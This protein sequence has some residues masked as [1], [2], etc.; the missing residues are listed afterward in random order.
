M[1]PTPPSSSDGS[2]PPRHRPNKTDHAKDTTEQDLWAFEEGEPLEEVV[3]QPPSKP[4][5]RIPLPRALGQRR[6]RKIEDKSAPTSNVERIT[7]NVG[8]SRLKPS[9]GPVPPMAAQSKPDSDFDDLD[10]WDELAEVSEKPRVLSD[11]DPAVPAILPREAT[12]AFMAPEISNPAPSAN[13]GRDEFSPVVPENASPISLRPRLRLSKVERIG[14]VMLLG[15]LLLGGTA[16]F[17]STIGRLPKNA[18]GAKAADFP[19]RGKYLTVLSADSFWRTPSIGRGTFRRGTALLPVITITAQGGP[20]A[21][22][23]FFRNS[24]G[25]A[26]GDAVTRF[27]RSGVKLEVASTAGFDDVGMY[28]A[29][30]T[31]QSKPWTIEIYEAPSENTPGPEFKKLFKINISTDRR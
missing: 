5:E 30:R 20:A 19:I 8:K 11:S 24:E 1:T 28:A 3:R 9:V 31:G 15:V 16:V 4:A 25:E 17:L 29:Y 7:V 2:L 12:V 10:Q 18:V 21:I 26:I 13:D 22:R 27:V 23:V 6:P 14:L